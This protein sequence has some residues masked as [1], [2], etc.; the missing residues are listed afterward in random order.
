MKV[1]LQLRRELGLNVPIRMPYER[2]NNVFKLTALNMVRIS[3]LNAMT[4]F[5]YL[6]TRYRWNVK[7]IGGNFFNNPRTDL[8]LHEIKNRMKNNFHKVFEM[9]V[10]PGYPSRQLM[11]YDEYH[12]QRLTE[13]NILKKECFCKIS[14]TA[15]ICSFADLTSQS[16][17]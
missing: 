3:M 12:E 4:I 7:T 15:Q 8:V 11:E 17:G 6:R 16:S 2:I 1:L 5:C 14:D 9:A 10:H 13:M